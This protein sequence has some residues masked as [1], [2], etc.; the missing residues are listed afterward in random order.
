MNFAFWLYASV[1]IHSVA[2]IGPLLARCVKHELPLCVSNPD[3]NRPGGQDPMPG[4]ISKLY[5]EM[6]KEAP[7]HHIG[8]PYASVYE[9]CLEALSRD[10]SSSTSSTTPLDL[11][12]VLCIGDSL[13]HDVLGARN[14]GLDSLFIANGVH[15]A[16]LGTTEGSS[17]S[18]SEELLRKLYERLGVTPTY[19][20]PSFKA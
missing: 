9:A 13:D 20:I 1:P 2:N 10:S 17:E 14:M 11:S 7:V 5:K 4:Q 15:C 19:S 3:F 8:K 12:R 6:W 16:D 18:P